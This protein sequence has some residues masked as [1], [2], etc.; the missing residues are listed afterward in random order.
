[1]IPIYQLKHGI[2]SFNYPR[3]WLIL[4]RLG[5]TVMNVETWRLVIC[6][7]FFLAVLS[8]FGGLN[9]ISGN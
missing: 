6:I 1:M 3:I 2:R 4:P 7:V 8:L 9:W 5:L